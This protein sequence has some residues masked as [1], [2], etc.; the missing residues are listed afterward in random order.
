VTF[1]TYITFIKHCNKLWRIK[2]EIYPRESP[3]V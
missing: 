2:N 3:Y 1:P